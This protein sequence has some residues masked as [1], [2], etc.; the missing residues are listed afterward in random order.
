MIKQ[1]RVLTVKQ[2]GL[3]SMIL[4]SVGSLTSLLYAIFNLHC[5][6]KSIGL[7]CPGCG[8]SRA[9]SFVFNGKPLEALHIQPT[10]T[11]LITLLVFS[12]ALAALVEIRTSIEKR[13][14]G[15][16]LLCGLLVAGIINTVFQFSQR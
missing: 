6:W 14:M 7:A 13:W 3:Q 8:C 5:P 4:L 12:A 11:L 2:V 16:T 10:A 15:A 9:V 1:Y